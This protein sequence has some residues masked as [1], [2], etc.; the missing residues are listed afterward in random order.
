MRA[1]TTA[2]ALLF[3]SGAVACTPGTSSN[4][5]TD[6]APKSEASSEPAIDPAKEAETAR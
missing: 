3:L 5:T 6:T 2:I 1:A 4:E